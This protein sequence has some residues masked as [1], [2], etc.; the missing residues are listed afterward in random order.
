MYAIAGAIVLLLIEQGDEVLW[1]NERHHVVA[2]Y[3]FRFITHLG[4]GLF[5]VL[6]CLGLLWVRFR[7]ALL[8]LLSFGSSAIFTQVLKRLVFSHALRPVAYF[9]DTVSLSLVE[10][11]E[12][13]LYNSFPSGHSTTSFAIMATLAYLLARQGWSALLFVLALLASLSRVYLAQHFFEDTYAGAWI[14]M[15]FV[16]L[17]IWIVEK[18]DRLNTPF[19]QKSL[20]RPDGSSY[21]NNH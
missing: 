14:A 1:L 12:M 21:V 2:N 5:A 11:V 13:H 20:G 18:S 10:G 15:C 4:D 9:G 3:F 8:M 19:W 16:T 17:S 6:L 7:D